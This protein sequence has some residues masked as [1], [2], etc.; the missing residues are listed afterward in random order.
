MRQKENNKWGKKGRWLVFVVK[1]D[2]ESYSNCSA[3]NVRVV[4]NMELFSFLKTEVI[5]CTGIIVIE[6][7]KE[8]YASS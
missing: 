4:D 5:L 3:L 8:R 6:G 2:L 7:Y 1:K